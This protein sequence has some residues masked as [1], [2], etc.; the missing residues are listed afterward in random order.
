MPSSTS[1]G[2]LLIRL[3]FG[4]TLAMHGA[5]KLV[6]FS[7]FS[8]KQGSVLLAAC[9]IAGELG[10]G[11]GLAVGLLTRLAG[12]GAAAVMW[13]VAFKVQGALQHLGQIGT[14]DGTKWEYPFLA[15]LVGVAFLVMGAVEY[16]LD[17]KLF[18]SKKK[19]RR[20]F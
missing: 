17:E 1:F 9:A 5:Q 16:S 12:V 11:L 18:P 7:D 10:G 8:A 4:L 19:P 20:I 13:F 15:G 2:L 14:G 3:G 6:H